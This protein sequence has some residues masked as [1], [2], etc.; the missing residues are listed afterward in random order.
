LISLFTGLSSFKSEDRKLPGFKVFPSRFGEVLALMLWLQMLF[1]I[2]VIEVGGLD[3][4]GLSNDVLV[5]GMFSFWQCLHSPPFVFFKQRAH[6]S[7]LMTFW[8][9]ETPLLRISYSLYIDTSCPLMTT[10][11]LSGIPM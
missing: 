4:F 1:L 11:T 3:G 6:L 7:P 2:A 9:T 8:I 10:A 5:A